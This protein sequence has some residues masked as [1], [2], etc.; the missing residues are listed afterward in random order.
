VTKVLPGYPR[1]PRRKRSSARLAT[2]PVTTTRPSPRDCAVES[3]VS[4]PCVTTDVRPLKPTGGVGDG[5]RHGRAG[6]RARI[7]RRDSR[8]GHRGHQPAAKRRGQRVGRGARPADGIAAGGAGHAP[9]AIERVVDVDDPAGEILVGDAGE[10]RAAPGDVVEAR[11]VALVEARR[12]AS[13]GEGSGDALIGKADLVAEA[14]RH[15]RDPRRV[16]RTCAGTG[17]LSGFWGGGWRMQMCAA[18]DRLSSVQFRTG[19]QPAKL[20]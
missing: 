9:D 7:A 18:D 20:L 3:A 19:L 2:C 10:R 6:D 15:R 13:G 11:A 16:L 4:S 12:N 14:V 1:P 8:V 17:S 5:H